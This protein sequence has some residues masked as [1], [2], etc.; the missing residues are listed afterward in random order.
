MHLSCH[1]KNGQNEYIL[2]ISFVACFELKWFQDKLIFP[3]INLSLNGSCKSSLLKLTISG[4]KT[5]LVAF[6]TQNYNGFLII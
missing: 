6:F 3:F 5:Y 2:I 4:I 1:G